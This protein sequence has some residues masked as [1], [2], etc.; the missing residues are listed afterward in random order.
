MRIT[1]EI[2]SKSE[3]DKLSALLKSFNINAVKI[4]STNT[5]TLTVNK[6]DKTIDPKG[7][8]GIWEDQPQTI[9]NIRKS[10]WQRKPGA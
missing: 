9:E 6:G 3:M 8:F 10:A 1:I 4:A 5:T 2:D 7:L